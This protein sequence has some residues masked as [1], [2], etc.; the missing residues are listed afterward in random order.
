MFELWQYLANPDQE[1]KISSHISIM[2][3]FGINT[4]NPTNSYLQARGR[5][6][7][8]IVVLFQNITFLSSH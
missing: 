1:R 4:G 2:E 6:I 7:I 3:Y 5:V 8:H